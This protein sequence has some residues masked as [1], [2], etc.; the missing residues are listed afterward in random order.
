MIVR[1]QIQ[2]GYAI[3]DSAAIHFVDGFLYKAVS[4]VVSSRAYSVVKE[5]GVIVEKPIETFFLGEIKK[6]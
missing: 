6:N 2:E 3:D 5:I 4:S 1:A